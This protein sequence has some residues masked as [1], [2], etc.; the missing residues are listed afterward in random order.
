MELTPSSENC[1]MQQAWKDVQYQGMRLKV[2][3]IQWDNT[4]KALNME[5]SISIELSKHKQYLEHIGTQ[6]IFVASMT[7]H[8]FFY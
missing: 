1:G 5:F 7:T 6:L 4:Y 8:L 3:R 2:L